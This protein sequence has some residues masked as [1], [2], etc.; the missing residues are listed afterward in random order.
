MSFPFHNQPPSNANF[1]EVFPDQSNTIGNSFSNVDQSLYL[2]DPSNAQLFL[3][4]R[5]Y[6]YDTADSNQK[7][8]KGGPSSKTANGANLGFPNTSQNPKKRKS[9]GLPATT[10]PDYSNSKKRFVWP[11]SLHQDFIGAVF[12]IGLRYSNVR[13]ILSALANYTTTTPGLNSAS[14]TGNTTSK[15]LNGIDL[16]FRD[17]SQQKQIEII[18]SLILK[19]QVFRDTRYYPR[20]SFYMAEYMEQEPLKAASLGQR[21]SHGS[22]SDLSQLGAP[23]TNRLNSSGDKLNSS[24]VAA[25]NKT[26]PRRSTPNAASSSNQKNTQILANI[27]TSSGSESDIDEEDVRLLEKEVA[28][29]SQKVNSSM[30]KLDFIFSFQNQ[31]LTE[32]LTTLNSQITR[33]D[34]IQQIFSNISN[35]SDNHIN[36]YGKAQNSRISNSVVVNRTSNGIYQQ[37][38]YG[39][40]QHAQPPSI[41]P[42]SSFQSGH[43]LQQQSNQQQSMDVNYYAQYSNQPNATSTLN[44]N[45]NSGANAGVL[46]AEQYRHIVEMRDH[47]N[48]HRK[49]MAQQQSQ[50]ALHQKPE[51]YIGGHLPP[52]VHQHSQYQPQ[53]QHSVEQQQQQHFSLDGHS[54][55]SGQQQHSHSYQG[56]R[57]TPISP[58][59]L[60]GSNA[61][62][63]IITPT[64]ANNSDRN[65]NP[66]HLHLPAS[67][68][69]VPSSGSLCNLD[70]AG[71][72]NNLT[73]SAGEGITAVGGTGPVTNRLFSNEEID[74]EDLFS[75]LLHTPHPTS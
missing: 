5:T 58:N 15:G 72:G 11:H 34:E 1:D 51:H 50:L 52:V 41:I 55:H 29:L 21:G 75:F 57:Q 37:G 7:G 19:F 68:D 59:H 25:V 17:H 48:L 22:S 64:D 36:G 10:A 40:Q 32:L 16:F 53:Q 65:G 63:T 12:D 31:N 62:Q 49:L 60:N 27:T 24:K 8:K 69:I 45:S 33:K 67:L 56:H 30:I 3:Q 46:P 70:S 54:H 74:G 18:K 9:E 13:D 61:P 73:S 20:K 66:N 38:M 6:S 23:N 43:S 39:A 26:S 4:N 28:E 47:I 42:P 35:L 14:M 71:S 2:D 44:S